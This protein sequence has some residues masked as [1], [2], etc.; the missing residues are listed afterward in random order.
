[1]LGARIKFLGILTCVP[2]MGAGVIFLVFRSVVGLFYYLRILFSSSLWFT[3]IRSL[4][5][6]EV[7]YRFKL[8]GRVF[9]F[10]IVNRVLGIIF[11]MRVGYLMFF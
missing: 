11:F 10:V 7:V 4:S 1:M 9:F 5:F 3:S 6:V 2:V 8:V